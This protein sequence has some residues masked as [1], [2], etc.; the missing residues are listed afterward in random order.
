[1]S[2]R[3]PSLISLVVEYKE[4]TRIVPMETI[5]NLNKEILALKKEN[6]QLKF[7]AELANIRND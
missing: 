3:P 6:Q 5:E 4:Y 1:M 2:N 7:A